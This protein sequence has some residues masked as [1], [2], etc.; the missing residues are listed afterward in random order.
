MKRMP[1]LTLD[2]T[3]VPLPLLVLT[4]IR[5]PNIFNL[6]PPIIVSVHYIKTTLI[7]LDILVDSPTYC[8]L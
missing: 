2:S 7:Y 6:C 4:Y 8:Y 3:V 5:N 1:Y